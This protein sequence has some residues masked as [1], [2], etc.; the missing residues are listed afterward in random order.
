MGATAEIQHPQKREEQSV[1][2]FSWLVG[3]TLLAQKAAENGAGGKAN[4]QP[5][6]SFIGPLVP[7][8]MLFA[9]FYFLFLRPQQKEQQRREEMLRSLKKNDRVITTGG[10]I[11]T[12]SQITPESKELTLRLND[13]THVKV[14]RWAIQGLWE[15]ARKDSGKE[16]GE[17]RQK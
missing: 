12:I 2:W 8:L 3:G 4:G 5:P 11:G 13:N 14:A 16:G 1:Q 15:D 9:L 7:F 17:S 6:T 10:L